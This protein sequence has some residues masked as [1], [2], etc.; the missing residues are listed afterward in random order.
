MELGI[1]CDDF[2]LDRS[3]AKFLFACLLVYRIL[4]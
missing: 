1:A 2:E 4:K 3:L